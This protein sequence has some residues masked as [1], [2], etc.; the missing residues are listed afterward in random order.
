MKKIIYPISFRLQLG[1]STEGKNIPS[2]FSGMRLHVEKKNR[3]L[4][5]AGGKPFSS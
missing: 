2:C 4:K 3:C 5:P 1:L